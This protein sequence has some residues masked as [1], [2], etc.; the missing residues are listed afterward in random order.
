MLERKSRVA[1][2]AVT[3]LLVAANLVALNWLVAGWSTVRV[4]LTEDDLY[5]I[6]P[7]TRRILTN[8]DENV[9]IIGYFSERTHPKLA[10]LVPRIVD[11]LEEYRAVSGGRVT[12]EIT[13]PG[14]DED[15]EAEAGQRFGVQSTPF[16]LASKYESA[17]VNAYFALVIQFG[18]QYVRY[19][20]LDLIELEP[21]PD[22][23][24]DVSLR[25]LEYDL[26]R[27]IKKVVYGFRTTHELFRTAGVPVALTAIWTPSTLP[28]VFADVPDTVRQAAQEL[29]GSSAGSFTFEEIDPS[30]D[31]ELADRV[32]RQYG[33]QPLTVSL[34]G[35]ESFYL[36]AALTIGGQTQ[37]LL[38][39]DESLTAAGV[40][41]TVEDALRRMTPGFLKTIG[42]VTPDADEIPPEIRQQLQL[43]PPPP[44]EYDEVRGF[45]RQDYAT[46]D[47][48]LGS[49]DGVPSEVDVLL[50]IEP[51]NLDEQ[52]VFNL[53]QY[54]MRGGRVVLFAGQYDV[55]FDQTGLAVL[56][57]ETGLEEWLAHFGVT[58]R[59]TLVL[60]DR[61]QP[62]PIP[63]VRQTPFGMV[64]TW[65]LAPYPYLVQVQDEGMADSDVTARLDAVGVY[66]GSPIEVDEQKA[67]ELDVRPIL[68]SSESSWTSDDTSQVTFV[69]YTVPAEGTEPQLLA[70]ALAGKFTSYF[71]DR[72][73]PGAPE[74]D[75]V[76]E[77][78]AEAAAPTVAL[79]ASPET[80][81]V[82]VGNAEMLSD[83]VARALAR[84]DGGFFLENL[85]FAEN[86]V[87]WVSLDNDMLEIRAQGVASRR[88]E[89]LEREQELGLE[90]LNYSLPVL[91]LL[92][93]G[94]TLR[95][96]RRQT[97]PL[98]ARAG[99]TLSASPGEGTR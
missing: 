52:A 5:S 28:D 41:E 93:L 57:V 51:R 32:W 95:W 17:I 26:T 49:P 81:L 7:A 90:A 82:V 44:P 77:A 35:E 67:G 98:T 62:L 74:P 91:I 50:V 18:D 87:D 54:L 31:P 30:S 76:S 58:V 3:V 40:R 61:N 79:E 43:P 65:E 56:P 94:L 25:N 85:R 89:R 64:R 53:D 88:L 21:T 70:V 66:W 86:L 20:F 97:A 24:V 73:L 71:A 16:R 84:V 2:L 59:E 15:V 45:L 37:Q 12:I 80:R 78:P 96:R 42:V 6:S 29:A 8:L 23:D 27:A 60:D 99:A 33:A 46:R 63:Q 75:S 4:D 38:L 55:S 10:P 83:F 39:A 13:D 36:Q 11:L 14:D 1:S 72:P 92:G 19:G 48:D 34:F 69:D 47:V 22:G 9:T 68:R